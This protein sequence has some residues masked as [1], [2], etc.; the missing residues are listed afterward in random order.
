V[1]NDGDIYT[2]DRDTFA[3]TYGTVSPG[4]YEKVAVWSNNSS[5]LAVLPTPACANKS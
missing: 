1:N 5:G 3:R 4:I 2:V